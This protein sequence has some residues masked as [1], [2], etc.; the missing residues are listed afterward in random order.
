MHWLIGVLVRTMPAVLGYGA[1]LAVILSTFD[2]CGHALTGYNKDPNVDEFERKQFLR[3]NYRTPAE[4]TF[5]ELGEG[6]GAFRYCGGIS[7]HIANFWQVSTLLDMK[8]GGGKGSRRSMAMRSRLPLPI[9]RGRSLYLGIVPCCEGSGYRVRSAQ[10]EG[11]RSGVV[12]STRCSKLEQDTA[13]WTWPMCTNAV[14]L[15]LRLFTLR[16]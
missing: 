14:S 3:K 11:R 4:Q 8:R 13:S 7:Q 16:S 10:W 1:G 2:F 6:R 12:L 9:D 15:R 5:E